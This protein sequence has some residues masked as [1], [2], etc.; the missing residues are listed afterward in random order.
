MHIAHCAV[1]YTL[2]SSQ[3]PIFK[4][5]LTPTFDEILRN[6]Q[7]LAGLSA[8][9][10]IFAPCTKNFI[11]RLSGF[12]ELGFIKSSVSIAERRIDIFDRNDQNRSKIDS[13]RLLLINY[14][15][16]FNLNKIIYYIGI[17]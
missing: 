1:S 17:E 15:I 7:H 6:A 3:G 2:F 13:Q 10:A 16:L 12:Y 5:N 8:F 9:T 14:R 4:R 11:V